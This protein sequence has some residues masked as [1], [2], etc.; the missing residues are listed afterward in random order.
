MIKSVDKNIRK[1]IMHVFCMFK[2]PEERL[3]MLHGDTEDI[4]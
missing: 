2:K 1:A 3:N 4:F